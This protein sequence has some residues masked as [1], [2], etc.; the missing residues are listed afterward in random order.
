M[1]RIPSVVSLDATPIQIDALGEAYNHAPSGNSRI[2]AWKKQMNERSFGAARRLITWSEWAK[3]SL[4]AD[5]GVPAEKVTVIPPGIDVDLWSFPPRVAKPDDAPIHL[6]FVGGDWGRK[7]GDTLLA[8]YDALSPALKPRTRLHLVTRS[9]PPNTT[10][11]RPGVH[12]YTGLTPNSE[13]LRNLY[14]QA[15]LFVFPT[16]GDC[17]PL[18]VLEALASGLPVVTTAV[19]ALAEAV[20]DGET[21]AIVP[22]DD[23][24]A[25]RATIERLIADGPGRVAMGTR[26]RETAHRRFDAAK[27]YVQ[28]VETVVET[29]KVVK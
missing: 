6:L 18:A 12:V 1:R 3:A 24:A 5:Y 19:G 25:L 4:V 27:N 14:A 9:A 29:A 26:A 2:E 16:R 23:A 17:L 15:D 28:L 11:G 7:G 21:G 22:V 10:D 8:A 20:R 13:G